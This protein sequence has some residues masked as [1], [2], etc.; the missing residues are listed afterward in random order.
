MN[1][2]PPAQDL[3]FYYTPSVKLS[4]PA[5]TDNNLALKVYSP[6]VYNMMPFLNIL[7]YILMGLSLG[8]FIFGLF[9]SSKLMGV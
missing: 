7:G 2:I 4:L 5:T 9:F 6:Q 1:F 8:G 3:S